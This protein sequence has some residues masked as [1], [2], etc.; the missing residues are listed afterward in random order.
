MT[1]SSFAALPLPFVLLV[2]WFSLAGPAGAASTGALSGAVRDPAGHPMAGVTVTATPTTAPLTPALATTDGAGRFHL[3][4]LRPATYQ[5]LARAAGQQVTQT[6]S[7][8]SGKTTEVALVLPL[9]PSPGRV[10]KKAA[11]TVSGRAQD[12]SEAEV[13]TEEADVEMAVAAPRRA[14]PMPLAAAPSTPP[15]A[16]GLRA[17]GR[18]AQA[19]AFN[20]ESYDH[21]ADGGFVTAGQQPLS[22]FAIDV[23]TA[24]YAN[25]RRFIT[26]GQVPPPGAVRVEE[27]INYFPYDYP[28]PG[29]GA[30]FAASFDE[31][32]CPWNQDARLVRV[33]LRGRDVPVGKRPPA[34]LVFLI[35]VSGSMAEPNK[36][37]L[38]QRSLALLVEQLRPDDRIALAVYAGASGLVL[39][40]TA[41]A[42]RAQI[43]AAIE[44]LGAGGSTNGAAGIT[45]AYRTAREAFRQGGNNRVIL[46][47]DGD[48]NVGVTSHDQLVR[49]IEKEAQSGVFLT[50]LGFGTGN[51]KDSTMEK[52]A[53]HG[54]GNYA[55][56]DSLAE[57][58]KVLVEQLSGTLLTIA[59]DVKIQVELN[60]ARVGAYRLVGY[61]NRRMAAQD[62]ND[63]RKDGG[64][65]GAGHTVT[66]LYEI[67]PPGPASARILHIDPLRYTT[68]GT[69]T[70]SAELLTVKVRYKEPDGTTSRKLEFPLRGDAGQALSPD[71]RFAA[72]VAAFGMVLRDSPLRGQADL[73]LV[74]R[75]LAAGLGQDPGGH[76]QGF[77]QLVAEA[78]ALPR[79]VSRR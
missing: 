59:K 16:A 64:E 1:R 29:N 23:D 39:P 6:V 67:L 54:N 31:G 57:A 14:P 40:P 19:D 2:L 25:T 65:I 45:L 20:T 61:E 58:R 7:V 26:A 27:L 28:A 48:F 5:V 49:L 53:D 69:S 30:A 77:V 56:I 68:P 17:Y 52:L 3:A 79:F 50:V 46:A 60:P 13:A 10:A 36:L 74:Q 63:D 42:E 47:T 22:T 43:L 55:Y 18:L 9:P 71:L 41:V 4:S 62:F 66:A 12:K 34:N 15:P 76:R 51:L 11:T 44:R 73:P 21:F 78:R 35:D 70:Q 72:A 37:P 33:G 38:V 75:L 24:S 32:P 8:A